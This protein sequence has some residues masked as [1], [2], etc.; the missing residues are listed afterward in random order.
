MSR[1][2][3][4][5]VGQS[6]RIYQRPCGEPTSH[7]EH[8]Q[9]L[10]FLMDV[11]SHEEGCASVYHGGRSTITR[12]SRWVA[13]SGTQAAELHAQA[14]SIIPCIKDLLHWL[15]GG[16]WETGCINERSKLAEYCIQIGDLW[17]QDGVR[18]NFVERRY[19]K[20]GMGMSC[21]VIVCE[22]RS[23]NYSWR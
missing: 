20:L 8:I 3:V 12:S 15:C 19:R 5:T 2:R 9:H 10:E 23:E 4:C 22:T 6:W 21:K 13:K 16:I 7:G 18:R 17:K 14:V 1:V 11:K